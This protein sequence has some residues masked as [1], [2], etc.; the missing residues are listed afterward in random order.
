M[1][2][3]TNKR[4]FRHARHMAEMSSFSRARIGCVV[5][6]KGRVLAAGMNSRKSHP[7]QEHYNRYRKFD[8]HC[9]PPAAL[10]AETAALVQLQGEDIPWDK[11][12]VYVYRIR[13]DRPHGLAAPCPAC[14]QYLKD[15]GVKSIYYTTDDGYAHQIIER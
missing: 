12:D 15:L 10:H 7:V 13:K 3:E 6:Y 2:T 1:L 5:A 14:M 8:D 11:V 9:W 4:C